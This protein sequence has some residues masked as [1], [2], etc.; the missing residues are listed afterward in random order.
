MELRQLIAGAPVT[1]NGDSWSVNDKFGNLYSY[2]AL[3]FT[4]NLIMLAIVE[5]FI[6]VCT[7]KGKYVS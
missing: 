2:V 1:R 6:Q 3:L 4:F 5:S 7:K